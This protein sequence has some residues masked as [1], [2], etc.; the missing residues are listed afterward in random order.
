MVNTYCWALVVKDGC[1]IGD[2]LEDGGRMEIYFSRKEARERKPALEQQMEEP[3][4]VVKVYVKEV[5]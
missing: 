2:K 3:L 1:L 4:R 5:E